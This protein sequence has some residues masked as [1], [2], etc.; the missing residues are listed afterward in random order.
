MK[1][2][3]QYCHK[4]IDCG[5][6]YRKHSGHIGSCKLN[7]KYIGKVQKLSKAQLDKN[8]KHGCNC[9]ICGTFYILYLTQKRILSNNYRKTCSTACSKSRIRT[10]EIKMKIS[11]SLKNS[12]KAKL[13]SKKKNYQFQILFKKKYPNKLCPRCKREFETVS[14]TRKRKYCSRYCYLKDSKGQ[15]SGRVVGGYR[16]GSGIGKR[17]RYKGFS[18]DSTLELEVAIYLDELGVRWIKNTKRF[19]FEWKGIK[20][21]Y[22]PDFYFEDL[23]LYLETK[24][25]WFGDKKE[26]TLYASLINE[27][28][29]VILLYRD[30]KA[31]RNSLL[32]ILKMN[33]SIIEEEEKT[34]RS[35]SEQGHFPFTEKITGLNPVRGTTNNNWC[36]ESTGND[37]NIKKIDT[38]IA[39]RDYSRLSVLT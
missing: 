12:E 25:F 19:Y 24:G 22:I 23:G 5:D 2:T 13:A 29:L 6:N 21:Y 37:F 35:S 39:G 1:K 31:D 16:E 11:Q 36:V 18:M 7:P 34:P 38:T 27:I 10:E 17:S 28:N 33:N 3:C 4:E 8:L 14:T 26:K 9:I 32:D 15:Y 20:T 30:W